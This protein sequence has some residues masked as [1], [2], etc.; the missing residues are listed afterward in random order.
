MTETAAQPCKYSLQTPGF[1]SSK[2][3]TISFRQVEAS[4]LPGVSENLVG[5]WVLRTGSQRPCSHPLDLLIVSYYVGLFNWIVS[6]IITFAL[7]WLS[8]CLNSNVYRVIK[9]QKLSFL[10]EMCHFWYIMT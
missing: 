1:L 2:A 7:G 5:L 9:Y 4:F 6:F 8:N 3:E 10:G